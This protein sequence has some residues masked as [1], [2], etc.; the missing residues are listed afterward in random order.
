MTLAIIL[1]F[2]AFVSAQSRSLYVP[3]TQ[4]S[5]GLATTLVLTNSDSEAAAVTLIVHPYDPKFL[6]NSKTNTVTVNIPPLNSKAIRPSDIVGENFSGGWIEVQTISSAITGSFFLI[7]ATGR[8]MEGSK[9]ITSPANHLIFP[10]VTTDLSVGNTLALVN[11]G[12][13]KLNRVNLSLFENN[14]Q[15]ITQRSLTLPAYAGWSGT[16]A[17]LVPG[18][19]SF[20]GYAVVDSGNE[21]DDDSLIGYEVFRTAT[22][23]SALAA[24]PPSERFETGHVAQFASQAGYSSTLVLVNDGENSRSV[25][26]TVGGLEYNGR[27]SATPSDS[28]VLTVG[29]HQ[30][31]EVPLADLFDFS[32]NDIIT[33]FVRYQVQDDTAG[34]FG[35]LELKTGEGRLTVVPVQGTGFEH[36]SLSYVTGKAGDSTMLVLMNPGTLPSSVTVETFDARGYA[37]GTTPVLVGPG[38][39]WSKL[40]GNAETANQIGGSVRITASSVVLAIQLIG[41]G[42]TGGT[43]T[44]LPAQSTADA[45]DQFIVSARD[46]GTIFSVDRGA[47]LS[48]P[49]GAIDQDLS[50]QVKP[51][52]VDDFPK[53][54][55]TDRLIGI[56]QGTP[57]GTQFKDPVRLRFPLADSL[58][59]GTVLPVSIFS[60]ATHQYD[61][62]GFVATVNGDGRSASADVTHFTIFAVSTN[63]S[64]QIS[65][66][67]PASGSVGATIEISGSGFDTSTDQNKVIFTTKGGG[68]VAATAVSVTANFLKTLVP[69]GAVSGKV[70]V[71]VG[72]AKSNALR[73][74]VTTVSNQA[75][76]VNAGPDQTIT[77]ANG[78][79]LSG[80]ATDDGL[81]T[82]S[83]LNY[84]WSVVS[85]PGAVVFGNAASLNTSASFSVGGTYT[86]RLTANDTALSSYDEVLITASA[87][88]TVTNKPPTVNAGS[89][90]TINLKTTNLAGTAVDDGLP[91][92]GLRIGW[93]KISGPGNVTFGNA[94]QVSTDATFSVIGT[95]TLRLTA[96]DTALSSTDDVVVTVSS[97]TPINV[98]PVVNAGP[99]QTITL[100][101][102][103]N[104][105]GTAAD[106]GL[107]GSGLTTTWASTAGPGGV[108]FGNAAA[109]TTTA[110]FSTPGT[111]TVSF[112]A[113]DGALTSI[114]YVIVTVIA[115]GQTSTN[116][117]PAISGVSIF[118][119]NN[120]WNTPVDSLPAQR[121]IDIINDHGG[122]NFH[123]DFGTTYNGLFNGIPV[124]VVAGNSTPKVKVSVTT[125]AS[126]SDPLPGGD[127]TSGFLPIPSNVLI[128]GDPVSAPSWS[129]GADHHLL[130]IDSDTHTLHELY[131]AIRQSDGS[132]VSNFYGHWDLNSNALREDFLTSTDA[133]G[134]ALTPGLI[135]YD[136]VQACLAKDP[137]GNSCTLGHAVRFTLDLTHGPHIWP[138]RH[139][140]NSGDVNNPPFGLRVRLKATVDTS[141]YSPTNRIILNTLKKYGAILADNGGDWFFQGSPDSRWDDNDLHSL[142]Q[143]VPSNSFEVVDTSRWIVA[144]DSGEANPNGS[145]IPVV[146]WPK[147]GAILAI[148]FDDPT[149]I[150]TAAGFKSF[151]VNQYTQSLGYGWQSTNGLAWRTRSSSSDPLWKDLAV[152]ELP[153]PQ[154][155]LID[156]PNGSYSVT[157][158]LGDPDFINNQGVTVSAEGVT[159]FT[160]TNT[161]Q[162]QRLVKTFPVAISDGQLTLQFGPATGGA[163]AIA[164][165]EIDGS[166]PVSA[167]AP[168]LTLSASPTSVSSGQSSTISWSSNNASSCSASGSWNGSK[169]LSGTELQSNL[170]VSGSYT[171]TCTGTGGST[172]QSV[173]IAVST[174]P[175]VAGTLSLNNTGSGLSQTVT[176]DSVGLFRLVFEASNNGGLTQWY[177]LLHDPSAQNN[178]IGPAL[179]VNNDITVAEPGLFQEVFYGTVP[180]DPKLYT[181]AANYYFP[182]SSRVIQIVENTASRIVVQVSSHP[183]AGSLGVLSNITGAVRYTIYPNGKIYVH[184][185]TTAQSAQTINTWF[186]AI[187]GLQN[188]G[189]TG[190]VPPDTSGWV[191][192]TATQNPYSYSGPERYIFAY[193][194]PQTPAP[195]TNWSKASILLI[196]AANNPF[197]GKQI[198]HS[199]NNF[200]R[201]GYG[202]EGVSMSAGQTIAQD[203]LIQLGTQGS[204]VLP[205]IKNSSVADPIANSYFTSPLP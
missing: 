179:G 162:G 111:Y 124:N 117:S 147:P 128:E 20:D 16:I 81:P 31:V 51:L 119:A 192:A 97:P 10:K 196:P 102:S 29:A 60:P 129:A 56:V 127:R 190:T 67:S 202:V 3:I 14:G 108:V 172:T 131:S 70:Y 169:S 36:S 113:S 182:T 7:D 106:D 173:S 26:I 168:T 25:S 197:Q 107:P 175:V 18:L 130:I 115:S 103:A 22:D 151:S 62:S 80:T 95:Y 167:A 101:A 34:V 191:R 120:V 118:P 144:L 23:L 142:A 58:E 43:L 123:P 42:G 166:G 46:G 140:A 136:Q 148:D 165:L 110:T 205:D 201:W 177:D 204:N 158:F 39:R 85:G 183:V 137:Q 141:A 134:L 35:Y 32:G 2:P 171:L 27:L 30:R 157:L 82:G 133:A 145:G 6:R 71:Q 38:G 61:Y 161:S 57:A 79:Q 146:T 13:G 199:W 112:T 170:A 84:L 11:T 114:D 76:S 188:P 69:V 121:A 44:T 75:P 77:L 53:P 159:Q 12:N 186:N 41:S 143:I 90:Q 59:P 21:T 139:D 65:N 184:S 164:G 153:S 33:G 135:R 17:D 174:S 40:M 52:H 180:D 100:P 9:L 154:T 83:P 156:L 50:I 1:S 91:G 68:V 181:R 138:A 74:K 92:A 66:I 73:F 125:Y 96:S 122:H 187:M 49:P 63:K 189:G 4:A 105:A 178:L 94:A 93:T 109:L 104:L 48:V 87:P 5:G 88:P 8:M 64:V 78:A 37:L 24:L 198:I 149:N 116:V 45:A 28:E 98:A 99:D 55:S 193:W 86:L 47:S 54:S 195:Y 200:M 185:E 72:A 155:F 203:Y 150:V 176:I 132:I 15:M 194:S 89:D 152:T 163:L 19:G 160:L 126:E